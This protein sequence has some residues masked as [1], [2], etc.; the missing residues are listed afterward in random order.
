MRSLTNP[1]ELTHAAFTRRWQRFQRRIAFRGLMPDL[2]VNGRPGLALGALA[3]TQDDLATI[4]TI[5]EAFARLF[6][7][8]AE[9]IATDTAALER[10]GFPWVAAELL[11]QE[12]PG[13]VVFGRFD[14]VQDRA[15][16]WWVLEYNSD[17]PSGLREAVVADAEVHR[18]IGRDLRRPN[19]RL[20]DL[21]STALVDAL[22]A[23]PG[24]VGFLTDGGEPED[25]AQL[26]Y[27][28]RLV[29]PALAER[30]W[31]TVLGD[32]A[33]IALRRDAVH[34]LGR[35]IH[36]LYR[37]YPFETM[38]G[39]AAFYDIFDAVFAGK[40]RLVNGLRGFLPQN[41]AISAWLWSH[42]DDESLPLE[43]RAL[44]RR[45]LPATHWISDLP[46]DFDYR[47]WVL[48]QVFGREGAEVYFGD[49]IEPLDWLRCRNWGTFVVQ[50]RIDTQPVPA[51][52]WDGYRAV[53]IDRYPTIGAFVV[54]ERFAGFYSRLG[55]PITSST[56]LWYATF[57][58]PAAS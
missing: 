53:V 32:V 23:G 11:A 43:D 49:T 29:E 20:A 1:E 9:Q 25:L 14:L 56:A 6:R 15:G 4:R 39:S 58:E 36:A 30:G 16:A 21:L 34:L 37:Y 2:T 13:R 54:D 12:P 57:V 41:K 35:R 42:R 19:D 38:F 45:H 46:V 28:R 33:N 26:E 50:R 18:W 17:T 40:L 31:S 44:I 55:G 27:T 51:L 7:L 3:L 10:I 48:K 22:G 24:C 52:G 5:V 47:D 8:A